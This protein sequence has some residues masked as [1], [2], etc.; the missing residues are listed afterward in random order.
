MQKCHRLQLQTDRLYRQSGNATKRLGDGFYE[1][2]LIREQINQLTGRRFLVGYTDDEAQ[3]QALMS[4]GVTFAQTYQ[5]T[6]GIA[7]SA[8]Q[9][10][11]LTSDIVWL[12]EKTITLADG[13]TV[14]ALVPQLYARLQTSDLS[15]TGALL[16]GNSVNLN[17][18]ADIN[19]NSTIAGR[20]I[21]SLTADNIHNLGGR[22]QA[23]NQLMLEAKHDI[24]IIGTTNEVDMQ[25]NTARGNGHVQQTNVNRLAGLYVNN[26]NGVLVASAGND[27]N[28]N[29]A[30]L[31][32]SGS[33][34]TTSLSAGNNLNIST[35]KT[36]ETAY[37]ASSRKNWWQQDKINEVGT[38]I[39]TN[40]D[41]TLQAGNNLTARAAT[42]TSDKGTLTT[43]AGNDLAIEAG[44]ATTDME[45]YRKSKKSG[46]LSSKTTVHHDTLNSTDVIGSTFSGDNV[47]MA[48]GNNLAVNASNIVGTNDVN[49]N[50]GNNITLTTEQATHDE[51][52]YKKTKKT[53]FSPSGGASIGY[54][55]S[56]LQTTN[57]SQQ[58]TNVGST[59]G[60]VEGDV[61]ITSG[62]PSTGSGRGTY[63]QTGSDVLTPQGDINIT[64]QQ[65]N[66]TNATDTYANQQTMKYKQTGLTLAVTNPV[67]SAIQTAQQMSKAAGKTDDPRMQALAAGTAALA[68]SNAK[69]AV[70]AGQA[71]A[72]TGN[73]A[74]DAANQV[75]GIN[76]SL[77]IGTSKS[78][79]QTTQTNTTAKSSTLNA[80]GDVNVSATGDGSNNPD[81]GN[82]N[83]IGSTIKAAHDVTLKAEDE[84]NLQ[85]AQ[86]VDTLN[87]TNKGS[88]A[89]LGIGFSLG[90][91]SNG[92]TINAGV[93]GS[94]GKTNG[95]GSNWT[96]TQ[97]QGGN[98]TGD[99]VT[100][101][102]AT[103]T[104]LIGA[105]V[106]GNQ[107][108]ADVGTSGQGN[109]NIQSLQDTNQYKDKQQSIGGS[110]SVGYGVVGGSI[111]YSDSKT[112]S[113][114]QSV[115][116]QSGIMAGD[117][118]FQVNVNGN[119]DL[120]GAV[121]ASTDKA[122]QD[123]KNSLTTQTLT[124]SNIENSAEY[125]AK[126]ISFGT[127]VGL[128][129]Q[130][131]DSYKNAP[132]A[133]AGSANLSDD[134]S[135]VTVSG[136]SG[137][138]V[139]ITDN[140]QQQ[141]LS[142][143]DTTTTVATLNR[144]VQ[145][146]LTTGT[147]AQGNTVTTA[148]TVDSNGNNLAGT[149][150][151]IFDQEQ[152]QRELNAQIQ[153]TQAFS[154]VA[155][156][157][158]ADFA[159]NKVKTLIAQAQ[160]ASKEGNEAL[161]N[162]LVDEAEKW[163]EGGIYRTALH[164]ALGGL[165]TGDISGAA[166]AGAVAGAAPLLNELQSKVA[167]TLQ[168]AGLGKESANTISQALA[169]LTSIGVGSA[170]G[171]TAGAGTALVVDTNN[172]QL[173]FNEQSALDKVKAGKTKE[174]QHRL[175]AA[176]CALVHCADGLSDLDPSKADKLK[177][178]NEGI[179]YFAEQ[180]QLMQASN[181]AFY[182]P[183]ND[184][185]NDSFTAQGL[186]QNL[187]GTWSPVIRSPYP[188]Y[189]SASANLYI[190]GGSVA[191]D[192]HTLDVY[193]QWSLGRVY[194]YSTSPGV[195][196]LAGY[197]TSQGNT[198]LLTGSFLQGG[199][200]SANVTV[201][202][203]YVPFLGVTTGVNHSYGGGTSSEIGLSFP[204]IS[205][206]GSVVSLGYGFDLKK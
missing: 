114:Y 44:Q 37:A 116:E 46:M 158:V 76:I 141:T 151:P 27:I 176:A 88:S 177:L 79:S 81:T 174:E 190:A 87:S 169:E 134:S 92:F 93:S 100:L 181:Y 143:K 102:S 30:E 204:V 33:D 111:S 11:Q 91:S 23:G 196:F 152:V 26:P 162:Q 154:Q 53:G 188:D 69:D 186:V 138:S 195:S 51:T 180:Q 168:G 192:M 161:G 185:K 99:T 129:K 202:T 74:N 94:K 67:I 130:S 173:H 194:P 13:S 34:G 183:P 20:D 133:S 119:T 77:S 165:L 47:N 63:N 8:A 61:N 132:T 171:G 101:N 110:I 189:I 16:T 12:V 125:S 113:N 19:N 127:G 42:V 198:A 199:G 197:M 25:I 54:G 105:Q 136:I 106:T 148:I 60:S 49:L 109:L 123:N 118:G 104:N 73:A 64:A 52:H 22:I 35:I 82:I 83:V 10:A 167:E 145:T 128:N 62:N 5:L 68:A 38:S 40:G 187:D 121:I 4:N 150:T 75:G 98:N 3:Y 96:E 95:N 86:N 149:L 108:V 135:S 201:P 18:T 203:G 9:I 17:T 48:A 70:S 56:K 140:T 137:G 147:D 175:D 200:I 153:I 84:I 120:K 36:S 155:P 66:I 65:V 72:P 58:V 139:S 71:I 126:G 45:K 2:R 166:G 178:Q 7:L 115:N 122:I 156:K 112:K 124:T 205:P 41:L 80:G 1:Q 14:Q 57:D 170:I 159:T 184:A 163:A 90:G 172:R 21:V 191:I 78:S 6:P 206:S 160:Q 164:T 24:N 50:A 182:Y 29:A 146:K 31:L 59:V 107:V 142:G 43:T 117:G 193:G 55:T 15:S 179:Q 103:D 85:A 89:S 32:N 144:D 131:D 39:Q 97:V 157:A 28:L